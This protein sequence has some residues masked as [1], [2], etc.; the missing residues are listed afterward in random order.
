MVI[1]QSIEIAE[2]FDSEMVSKSR[3]LSSGRIFDSC[4]TVSSSQL[5]SRIIGS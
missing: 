4:K 2:A 1:G 5:R 3:T